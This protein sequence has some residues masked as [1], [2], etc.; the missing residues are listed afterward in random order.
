MTNLRAIVS[1]D[2]PIREDNYP[3]TWFLHKHNDI[4]EIQV[5]HDSRNRPFVLEKGVA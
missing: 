4:I 3:R 5:R 2:R 1:N